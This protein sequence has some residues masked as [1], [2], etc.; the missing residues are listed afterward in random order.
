MCCLSVLENL[1]YVYR[2]FQFLLW[3]ASSLLN[4]LNFGAFFFLSLLTE[5]LR[6]KEEK[7]RRRMAT[8]RQREIS[9][10]LNFHYKPNPGGD[11]K[12]L[13]PP[14]FNAVPRS[15]Y[16]VGRA[17]LPS[18]EVHEDTIYVRNV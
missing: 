6:E 2:K 5:Y 4:A 16:N 12:D 14:G 10:S 18:G 9:F 11:L 17:A 3:K 13:S 8:Q 1:F 15:C 7:E